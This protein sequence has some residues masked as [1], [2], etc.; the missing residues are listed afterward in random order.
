[1]RSAHSA[2]LVTFT[3]GQY[4]TYQPTVSGFATSRHKAAECTVDSLTD[5]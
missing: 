5:F 3:V 1:M 2:M 4:P